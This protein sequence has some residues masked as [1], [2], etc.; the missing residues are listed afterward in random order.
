MVISTQVLS[1]N[2]TFCISKGIFL[3]VEKLR[4]VCFMSIICKVHKFLNMDAPV[5]QIPIGTLLAA[6]AAY[7]VTVEAD[8]LEC[9]LVNLISA[10]PPLIRGYIAHAR[11]LVLAKQ[12]PFPEVWK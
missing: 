7:N 10:D 2:Q 12:N 6:C 3:I 9:V 1:A 4:Q 8:E 5:H 11:C